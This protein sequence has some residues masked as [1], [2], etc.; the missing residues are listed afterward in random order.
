MTILPFT[1]YPLGCHNDSECRTQF[2]VWL[3]GLGR[4]TL[5]YVIVHVRAPTF[6]SGA[7]TFAC[8]DPRT[9]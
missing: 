8:R 5:A 7:F 1:S 4:A 6:R 2:R 9:F 3:P